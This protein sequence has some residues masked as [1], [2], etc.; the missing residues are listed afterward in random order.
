MMKCHLGLIF[1]LSSDCL[2]LV[3]REHDSDCFLNA[4][5]YFLKIIF[6]NCISKGLEN[7][8]KIE[9]KKK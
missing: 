8:K 6:H 5:K 1:F 4:S 3:V 9:I 7:K 2:T